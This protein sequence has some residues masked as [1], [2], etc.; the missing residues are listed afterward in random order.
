MG[1]KG[2]FYNS[3]MVAGRFLVLGAAVTRW[4]KSLCLL[5][6]R[7]GAGHILTLV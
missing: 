3:N 1:P 7:D 2:H 4:R 6:L 5:G